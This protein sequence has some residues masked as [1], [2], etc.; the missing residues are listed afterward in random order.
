MPNVGQAQTAVLWRRRAGAL[1]GARRSSSRVRYALA[2]RI[3]S[4][5]THQSLQLVVH[6]LLQQVLAR[7]AQ[8]GLDQGILRYLNCRSTAEN[9]CKT[10]LS[11]CESSVVRTK[12]AGELAWKHGC[13][14]PTPPPLLPRCESRRPRTGHFLRGPNPPIKSC[15]PPGLLALGAG[16]ALTERE[17]SARA[18]L[19]LQVLTNAPVPGDAAAADR[20]SAAERA[21][22]AEELHRDRLLDILSILGAGLRVLVGLRPGTGPGLPCVFGHTHCKKQLAI[23][24]CSRRGNGRCDHP[25]TL[26]S[27]PIMK[28]GG[29]GKRAA[30]LK[31]TTT[32]KTRDHDGVVF[33]C[34]CNFLGRAACDGVLSRERLLRSRGAAVLGLVGR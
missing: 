20:A 17:T 15:P 29:N 10:I 7:P 8:G 1:R 14:C 19:P 30:S 31:S 23:S 12:R 28:H 6:T 22:A 3:G 4:G 24:S 5:S 27:D 34:A 18:P 11:I 32:Q 9:T 2:T 33:G 25:G 26:S 13:P 16:A 21:R